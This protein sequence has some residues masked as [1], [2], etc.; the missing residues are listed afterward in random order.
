MVKPTDDNFGGSLTGYLDIT[1]ADLV[2]ALGEPN[3]EGD[4]Y[5][6]DAEWAVELSDG[7]KASIYNYKDGRHYLGDEG[8][9]VED[10]TEWHVGSPQGGYNQPDARILVAKLNAEIRDL[11]NGGKA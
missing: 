6:T 2:A 10:I 8:L 11:L 9:A 1:Y 3:A 4:G 5:K 7:T